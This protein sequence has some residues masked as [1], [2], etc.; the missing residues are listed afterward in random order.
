MRLL[1][2][3]MLAAALLTAVAG[4]VTAAVGARRGD[5][6]LQARGRR[7]A[8]LLLTETTLAFAVLE[9]AFGRSDFSY[10][11]VAAHSSLGTP[12]FYQ[13]T[14]AWSSQEGSLLLWLWL[15]SGWTVLS[16]RLTHR[17]LGD[18]AAYAQAV[19]LCFGAFFAGLLVSLASPFAGLATAPADGAGL[20]PLLR[21]RIAPE[22]HDRAEQELFAA[23]LET[24]RLREEDRS[25]YT[26]S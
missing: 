23:V 16:A 3:A 24:K 9:V 1:G 18:V 26:T 25:S 7:C 10:A 21:A 5:P 14:A 11:T 6:A 12:F 15:L 20:D 13:L 4:A 2:S 17:R 22:E 8:A 19:L